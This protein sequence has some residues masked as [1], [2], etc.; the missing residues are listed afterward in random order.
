MARSSAAAPSRQSVDPARRSLKGLEGLIPYSQHD[1]LSGLLSDTDLATLR[2][3]VTTGIGVNTLRAL[4]SDLAY[5]ERWSLAATGEA[6][7]WPAGRDLILKFIAHHLWDPVRR[8]SD[9]NHGMPEDVQAALRREGALRTNARMPQ[10]GQAPSG[11]LAHLAPVARRRG[12][13]RRRPGALSTAPRQSR[14]GPPTLPQ[15]ERALTGDVIE[16]LLRTCWMNRPI[17]LRD[18]AILL[19]AFGSGGRRRSEVAGFRVEDVRFEADLS[20]GPDSPPLPAASLRLGR[21][22]TTDAGEGAIAWLVGKPVEALKTWMTV[23][24]IEKGPLFRPID[25]WG[26]VGSGAL[27]PQAINLIVKKRVALA[28]SSRI[29]SPRTDCAQAT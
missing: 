22:K 23:A 29:S 28:G 2:H 4:T 7:P 13:I 8:E 11:P 12:G 26:H 10:H 25:Q 15:S 16:A 17:D 14:L 24:R 9:P 21:T 19:L 27:S 18:R 1:R 20:V 6:L 5:L 3:L